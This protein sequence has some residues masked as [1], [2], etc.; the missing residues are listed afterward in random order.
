MSKRRTRRRTRV[1]VATAF[2]A[3]ALLTSVLPVHPAGAAGSDDAIERKAV[4]KANDFPAGWEKQARRAPTASDLDVCAGIQAVND[5]LVDASARSPEFV[6]PDTDNVRATNSVVVLKSAK[7]AR[8]YLVPYR[9]P[10]AVRCLET[11]T[12]ASLTDAGYSAVGVYVVPHAVVPPGAD[13]AAGFTIEI[14]ITAP[15]TATRP[16]QTAVIHKDV[17]VVRVGRALAQF[18]FLSPTKALPEQ[19]ELV[20]A[21]V[22]RLQDALG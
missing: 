5:D 3:A 10:D 6:R 8:G 20:D 7:A 15:A 14:T 19:G 12:E 11:L 21:V 1:A 9:E 2:A 13:E 22:G 16:A 18:G 4:L 17:L